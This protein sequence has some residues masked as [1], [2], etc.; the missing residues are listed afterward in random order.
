[1]SRRTQ[2]LLNLLIFLAAAVAGGCSSRNID[3][4][5]AEDQMGFGVRMARSNLWRE[6]L[7]RF[8]RAVEIEPGN[9]EALNNLAVAYEGVGEFEK[10]REL[11]ARALEADRSNPHIQKNYSRFVEFY[12]R[13]R[14]REEAQAATAP[15][16]RVEAEEESA[17]GTP[18]VVSEP[19]PPTGPG[20]LPVADEPAD[21]TPPVPTVP[22]TNPTP[23]PGDL[24]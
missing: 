22:P 24:S 3:L 9:P 4:S 7:F 11:Y 8:E 12:S 16:P 17:S 18:V 23:P 1:M 5:K 14:K 20:E 6:A 15:A 21:P 19:E 13:N 2:L 10:A